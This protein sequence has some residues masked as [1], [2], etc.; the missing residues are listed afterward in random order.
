MSIGCFIGP[1]Y[2]NFL[3]YKGMSW[4]NNFEIIGILNLFILFAFC[5]YIFKEKNIIH[6]SAVVNN[7]TEKTGFLQFFHDKKVILICV[8]CF[9]Y[10]G[11]HQSF[12]VWMPTYLNS[13]MIYTV[14]IINWLMSIFWVSVAVG[15]FA[16]GYLSKKINTALYFSVSGI[17]GTVTMLAGIFHNTIIVWRISI[18]TLGVITGAVYPTAIAL[19]CDTYPECSGR[20]TSVVCISALLGGM[21][22]GW[23]FGVIVQYW[24]SLSAIIIV[25]TIPLLVVTL[26]G[27]LFMNKKPVVTKP[28]RREQ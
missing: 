10:M 14:E 22:F 12:L 26:L 17:V 23:L 3:L 28:Q 20:I 16:Y 21:F 25:M 27:N 2:S 19:A 9:F 6:R 11:H 18:I 24:S 5:L 4:G 15:R 13:K 7:C 1:I 8:L